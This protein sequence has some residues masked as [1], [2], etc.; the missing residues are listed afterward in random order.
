MTDN[1]NP[2]SPS[3]EVVQPRPK[4]RRSSRGE[5]HIFDNW[6]KGCGLCV[7]FCPAGVLVLG[8]EGRPLSIY[9]ERCITCR[10]CELH[11]PDLAIFIEEA[12]E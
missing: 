2:T 7:E 1:N 12:P 5:V 9:P 8:I 6:C 4:G 3:Q 10:W 11:C